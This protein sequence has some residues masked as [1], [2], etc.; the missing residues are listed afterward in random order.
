MI[1]KAERPFRQTHPIVFFLFV[2]FVPPPPLPPSLPPHPQS[3]GPQRRF[4]FFPPLEKRG[5]FSSTHEFIQ[6]ISKAKNPLPSHS[7]K[8][9]T[10]AMKRRR[11]E[12]GKNKAGP[13]KN[14]KGI[15]HIHLVSV[16]S[17]Q[18]TFWPSLRVKKKRKKEPVWDDVAPIY[19]AS[20]QITWTFVHERWHLKGGRARKTAWRRCAKKRRL[21]WD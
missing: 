2:C 20:G 13:I 18:H 9:R 1:P 7:T 4:F 21:V 16:H 5:A 3:S 11:K 6:L 8:P 12:R 19:I 10:G 14:Q 17:I 15:N